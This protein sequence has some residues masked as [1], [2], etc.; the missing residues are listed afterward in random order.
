[1]G[2][3]DHDIDVVL[4]LILPFTAAIGTLVSNADEIANWAK[5]LKPSVPPRRDNRRAAVD[6]DKAVQGWSSLPLGHRGMNLKAAPYAGA[7]ENG[8]WHTREASALCLL[9]FC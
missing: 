9:R 3:D 7:V 4:V 6:R 5:A 8:L 1:L 2:G